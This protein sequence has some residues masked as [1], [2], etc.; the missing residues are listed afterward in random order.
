MLCDD[1]DTPLGME[2]ANPNRELDPPRDR[3]DKR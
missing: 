2:G 1:M 3:F